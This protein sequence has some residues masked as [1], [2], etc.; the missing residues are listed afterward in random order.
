MFDNDDDDDDS[1]MI[2]YDVT[3]WFYIYLRRYEYKICDVVMYVLW[4]KNIKTWWYFN[5]IYNSS[6]VLNV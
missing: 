5:I 4:Y 3:C 2:L 1:D 6:T